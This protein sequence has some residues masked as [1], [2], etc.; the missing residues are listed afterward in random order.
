MR[1]VLVALSIATVYV[2]IETNFIYAAPDANEAPW[3]RHAN[4]YWRDGTTTTQ[5]RMQLN[6]IRRRFP[7]AGG[8]VFNSGVWQPS[9]RWYLRDFRPTSSAT[10][11]DLV[12]NPN[13]SLIEVQEFKLDSIDLEESWEPA[14]STLTPTR[15][16]RF[17]FTAIAWTPLRDSTIAIAIRPRLDL[18]P[19]LIIPPHY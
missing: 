8:T 2:Q 3:A 5:A 10:L 11:A 19:T 9:L 18:A 6:E 13:P 14:L 1:I 12:I 7:E 4:L 15:A 16:V 17:I